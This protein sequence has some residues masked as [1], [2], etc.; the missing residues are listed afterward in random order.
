MIGR[1][2]YLADDSGQPIPSRGPFMPQSRQKL[3]LL[4]GLSL[5][6]REAFNSGD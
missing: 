5:P 4:K 1:V 6:I 3:G 2:R